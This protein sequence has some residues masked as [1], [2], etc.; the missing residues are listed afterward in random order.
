MIDRCLQARRSHAFG[1][2][3]DHFDDPRCI[4]WTRSG[5]DEHPGGL[6]VLLSNAGEATKWMQVGAPNTA[7]VDVTEHVPDTIITD[8]AGW[9][10]FRCRGRSVS[11]WL[12]R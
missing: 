10:E 12:P 7:Y 9:A 5:N 11:V 1:E 3:R 2:Q 8:D 4:G 6:A